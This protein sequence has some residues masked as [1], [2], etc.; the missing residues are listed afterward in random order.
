MD[1]GGRGV[2][3]VCGHLLSLVGA[4]VWIYQV[5]PRETPDPCPER[6]ALMGERVRSRR[7][8]FSPRLVDELTRR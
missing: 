6:Q 3:Q 7:L 5:I 2:E 4:R 1:E 8:L